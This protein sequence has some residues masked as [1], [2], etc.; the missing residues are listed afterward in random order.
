MGIDLNTTNYVI[1]E[2]R[3]TV[4]SFRVPLCLQNFNIISKVDNRYY[5][6]SEVFYITQPIA[7]QL[8]TVPNPKLFKCVYPSNTRQQQLN[9]I[10]ISVTTLKIS[11]ADY[12]RKRRCHTESIHWHS[13]STNERRLSFA[14]ACH[15]INRLITSL[16]P[17]TQTTFNFNPI[18]TKLPFDLY[19]VVYTG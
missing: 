8:I 10:A 6:F 13:H 12:I 4:T 5:I 11:L 2:L 1:S 7:I 19:R 3:I 9:R 17:A 15:R 18:N 16:D 14:P